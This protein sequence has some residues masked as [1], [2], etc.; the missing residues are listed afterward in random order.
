[1]AK[2][3]TPQEKN[4]SQ[5]YLDLIQAGQLADYAPVRGCMIIRPTGFAI[6]KRCKQFWIECLKKQGIKTPIF[7][8]LF[9]RVFCH[10][11]F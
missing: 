4:F 7:R 11:L 2:N 3:I 6:W 5:W 8:S 1:M 10:Y 9:Q